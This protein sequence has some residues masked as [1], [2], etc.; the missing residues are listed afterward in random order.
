MGTKLII[1]VNS[2]TEI[3][4]KCVKTFILSLRPKQDWRIKVSG[5]YVTKTIASAAHSEKTV[6]NFTSVLFLGWIRRVLLDVSMWPLCV[7]VLSG[8]PWDVSS[9]HLPDERPGSRRQGETSDICSV[10]EWTTKLLCQERTCLTNQRRTQI[11]VLSATAHEVQKVLG[12]RRL[13]GIEQLAL[14]LAG[15]GPNETLTVQEEEFEC[16]RRRAFTRETSA[17]ET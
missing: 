1:K 8:P 16:R 15:D 7:L 9:A 17:E 5:C 14:A 11:W 4:Q 2:R 3:V 12:Y 13:I 6:Y 10:S